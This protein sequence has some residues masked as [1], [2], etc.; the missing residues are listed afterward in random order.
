MDVFEEEEPVV[1]PKKVVK[2]STSTA[3]MRQNSRSKMNSVEEADTEVPP[4]PI[5]P[6]VLAVKAV[7][8]ETVVESSS[9]TATLNPSSSKSKL[10]KQKKQSTLEDEPHLDLNAKKKDA[11]NQ[12]SCI[13][14]E[15][16]E[17]T[18]A[19]A[20]PVKSTKATSGKSSIPTK[21]KPEV[22][23]KKKSTFNRL[24]DL[25]TKS[26]IIEQLRRPQRQSKLKSS[27]SNVSDCTN[28]STSSGMAFGSKFKSTATNSKKNN[29][30]DDEDLEN[31][32]PVVEESKHASRKAPI[33]KKK[34]L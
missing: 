32:N 31:L 33:R 1:V 25:V 13:M 34:L 27:A 10:S 14:L 17:E 15:S 20:K 7:A 24:T 19:H 4:H 26:P 22:G 18:E 5:V 28:L 30:E 6:P 21:E 12:N 29:D 16:E 9:L 3:K 8:A 11:I 2:K 23:I